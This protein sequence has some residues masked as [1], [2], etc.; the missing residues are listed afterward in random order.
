MSQIVNI[1]EA[2]SIAIHSMVLIARSDKLLNVIKIAEDTCTSKHHVAKVL[3]RLV[4]QNYLISHRGPHGGFSLK[5]DPSEITFMEL[6]EAI[7]GKIEIS[8][9][10]MQKPTCPFEKCIMNNVTKNMTLQFQEYMK[11]QKLSDYRNY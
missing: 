4:K 9:C 1:S 7:E 3:Q 8:D 5:K 2:A 6:Y 11:S 10:P